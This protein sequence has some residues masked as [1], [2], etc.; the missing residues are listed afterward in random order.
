MEQHVREM[1]S[2]GI[3]AEELAIQ[4]VGNPRQREPIGRMAVSER[5][6]DPFPGYTASDMIVGGDITEI[7]P[8]EECKLA[9][10]QI[11]QDRDNGQSKPNSC[12][13]RVGVV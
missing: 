1:M 3:Q 7:V 6:D 8:V 4:H 12:D 9:D 10:R 13:L 5:P 11:N 2:G